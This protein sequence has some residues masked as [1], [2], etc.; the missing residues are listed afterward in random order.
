MTDR[1]LKIGYWTVGIGAIVVV[2]LGTVLFC[3]RPK[4]EYG[5]KGADPCAVCHNC[6]A[7][8]HCLLGG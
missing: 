1:I 2:V 5:C 7:C 4:H 3:T 8:S 6:R